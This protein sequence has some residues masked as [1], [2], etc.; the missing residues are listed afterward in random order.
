[1][2]LGF[3]FSKQMGLGAMGP[4]PL[5]FRPALS[6]FFNLVMKSGGPLG[7][8]VLDLGPRQN[9]WSTSHALFF[10]VPIVECQFL[11]G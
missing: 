11:R 5:R 1:M 6:S 10:L 9:E 3:P 4:D 8:P 2:P 7:P